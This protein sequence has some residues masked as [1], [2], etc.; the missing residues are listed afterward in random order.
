MAKRLVP[1]RNLFAIA[2]LACFAAANAADETTKPK[3]AKELLDD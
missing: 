1:T 3:S 2:L